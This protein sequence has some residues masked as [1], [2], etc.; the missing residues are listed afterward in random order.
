MQT[1]GESI[2]TY[3][4]INVLQFLQDSFSAVTNVSCTIMDLEGN[5][6][7]RPSNTIALCMEGFRQ[8]PSGAVRCH[9]SD[10]EGRTEALRTGRETVYL[11][12]N[13]LTDIAAP[14]AVR[15]R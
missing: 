2:L 15:K 9:V 10:Q 14:I 7:T 1:S 13:G 6:I 5:F 11:C 3:V 8:P 12:Q 4:D